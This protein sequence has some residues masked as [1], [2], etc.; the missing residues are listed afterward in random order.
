MDLFLRDTDFTWWMLLCITWSDRP[1]LFLLLYTFY[2]RI[3][4]SLSSKQEVPLKA[5]LFLLDRRK[6]LVLK[7]LIKLILGL[8]IWAISL[9]VQAT[10]YKIENNQCLCFAQHEWSECEKKMELTC[11]EKAIKRWRPHCIT[12]W[13]IVQVFPEVLP[14]PFS[15]M[16]VVQSFLW[17]LQTST[18]SPQCCG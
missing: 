3:C 1:P 11:W 10:K 7:K 5:T 14:I 16:L 12:I 9:V 2:L 8:W 15:M 13:V 6:S 18:L 4:S 17:T